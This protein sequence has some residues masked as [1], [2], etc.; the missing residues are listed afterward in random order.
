MAVWLSAWYYG[1]AGGSDRNRRRVAGHPLF[2][3]AAGPGG[4]HAILERAG[5]AGRLRADGS[6]ITWLTA[7]WRDEP[8]RCWPS[9]LSSIGDAVLV[10]DRD[11]RII[12]LNPVAETLTGWPAEEARGKPAGEVLRL[13]DEQTRAAPRTTRSRA[14]S[15]DRA[16]T[17]MDSGSA[18]VSRSGAE[19]PVEHSAVSGARP[20]RPRARRHPGFPRYRQAPPVGRAG[21]ARRRRWKRWSGWPAAWPAISTMS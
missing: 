9:T 8:P 6:L 19:V 5:A 3:S 14:R 2:L 21:H 10:T 17:A 11:G 12:F 15:R 1:R 13:L 4:D 18:L 7:S 16:V 20:C